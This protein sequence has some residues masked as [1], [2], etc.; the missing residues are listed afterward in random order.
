MKAITCKLICMKKVK[1]YL[2]VIVCITGIISFTGIRK[3]AEPL[4][5]GLTM[6]GSTYFAP[7]NGTSELNFPNGNFEKAENGWPTGGWCIP[8]GENIAKTVIALTELN[9]RVPKPGEIAE[10]M[11]M[12]LHEY[13]YIFS[14]IQENQISSSWSTPVPPA[15]YIHLITKKEAPEG[16]AY[17]RITAN[18]ASLL[19]SPDFELKSNKPHL[20]SM[21]I[22]SNTRV[23]HC[24]LFWF[25]AGL[26]TISPF[27]N[28]FVQLPWTAYTGQPYNSY[29]GLPDTKGEWK[30]VGIYFRAPFNVVRAH[31][32][33]HCDSTDNNYLDIDDVQLR[34]ATEQE[35]SEAYSAWRNKFPANEIITNK[36]EDGKYL[37]ATVA[38]L[39]G[40]L[41]IPG[42]PFLIWGVG[43]SWTNFLS[44]LE[45]WRQFIR[46][47][48]PNAPEIVYKRRAGSGTPYEY[49]HGWVHTQ[50]LE[51][52]PDLV[53][54][55]TNGS[56][57][58]LEA[59]LKDIRQHSTA[60]IIIPS[61]HF[62][63]NSKLIP[64]QINDPVFDKIRD[65]CQKYNAQFVDNR[66]ELAAW[67]LKNNQPV[68]YLLG[69]PVHQNEIGKLLINENISAHFVKNDN[70]AYN[71]EQME[72]QL[73]LPEAYKSVDK[74]FTFSEGWE[75]KD[76]MLVSSK[77]GANI[78]IGFSGNRIDLIGLKT[79]VGGDLK[80]IIDDKPAGQ[81]PAYFISFVEPAITN[82][83]HF[84]T[85]S[86]YSGGNNDTGPHGVWLGNDI[87]PQTWTI[88]M[89]DNE[90]NYELR[91][92]KTRLDGNGNNRKMFESKSGQII[93]DPA[94]WR[95]PESNINGDY[96]TF[97][98]YRCTTNK[99]NFKS[100]LDKPE[101]FSIPLAQN[102]TN[103]PHT[104]EIIYEGAGEVSIGSFYVFTPML[105]Y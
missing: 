53:F 5:K 86:R 42:K 75:L 10:A 60:D 89:T 49:A 61:L 104:L 16:K 95:H 65:I 99:V 64:Q 29:K 24:P 74:Q 79:T 30:R 4:E 87:N 55:Y 54:C 97:N 69:D 80:I 90:G 33:I 57:E 14:K 45:P 44:D 70:P 35:F 6:I 67:L 83:S 51:E 77:S 56:L 78:K 103:G 82:M 71:P 36:E 84:G 59:M 102:L 66:R 21:W 11:K 1:L 27:V 37:A 50:V 46:Q 91:G 72:K 92:R 13:S 26:D 19:R 100:A 88:R 93:I 17:L 47:H 20:L 81:F 32:T 98:V 85:F 94:L 3:T 96:W 12:V 63:E 62:F 76:K 31:W 58:G 9:Q 73:F 38:K 101:V 23:V 7:V 68:K 34:T 25:D 8:N 52:Q 22:R 105:K 48:F 18:K 28:S 39:E 43:S 40:K 2:L 41:G 15:G